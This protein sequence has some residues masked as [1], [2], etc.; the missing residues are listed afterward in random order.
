MSDTDS[1]TPFSMPSSTDIAA[2]ERL[3]RE[4]QLR[5]LRAELSHPDCDKVSPHN[6]DEILAIARE[7]VVRKQHEPV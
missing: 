7:R 6:M 3:S 2:W 5:R 1:T 4:E